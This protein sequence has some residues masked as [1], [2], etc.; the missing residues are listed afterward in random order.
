MNMKKILLSVVAMAIPALMA[1]AAPEGALYLLGLNGIDTPEES[2]AL[3]FDE[4]RTE[5]DIDE[6]VYRWNNPQ[7]ELTQVGEFTVATADKSLVLGY[8]PDNFM[9]A[10]NELSATSSM[11]Y[12]RK[13]GQPVNCT[14]SPGNYSVSV[15][16]FEA[17]PED[18]ESAD[19][20]IIQMKS[21]DAE[22]ETGNYYLLGFGGEEEEAGVSNKFVKTV[23]EIDGETVISYSYRNS[24]LVHVPPASQSMIWTMMYRLAA[25]QLPS[26]TNPPWRCFRKMPL[27]CPVRLLRDTTLS[28]SSRRQ[29]SR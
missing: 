1:A 4:N 8:D 17:D 10:S 21:L 9:G 20:W 22:E 3:A 11:M 2:L 18:A 6:G 27:P 25:I 13:D 5:D 26:P 14:L 7:I 16:L 24:R 23:E 28:I 12:L 15:V 29:G 19:S